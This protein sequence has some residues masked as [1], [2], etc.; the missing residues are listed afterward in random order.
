MGRR[1]EIDNNW[2]KNSKR[3]DYKRTSK[4]GWEKSI[5]NDI[6]TERQ[7]IRYTKAN[8]FSSEETF[9]LRYVSCADTVSYIL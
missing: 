1:K 6:R 2:R 5:T 7:R 8:K 3:G 9:F 4:R